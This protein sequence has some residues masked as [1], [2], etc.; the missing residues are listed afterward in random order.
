MVG[1][2]AA[3]RWR[4]VHDKKHEYRRFDVI[5][6]SAESETLYYCCVDSVTA[7]S[8]L[9]EAQWREV[10]GAETRLDY[11]EQRIDSNMATTD[12]IFKYLETV[13]NT[14][15]GI[16]K[17]ITTL[18]NKLQRIDQLAGSVQQLDRALSYALNE[19]N[20]RISELEKVHGLVSPPFIW[21]PAS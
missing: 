18:N 14:F 6:F 5:I 17:Q 15:D 16:F 1:G 19:F 21:V 10:F 8:E 13:D 11:V 20:E 12:N 2:R 4:G 9:N 3:G 7:G